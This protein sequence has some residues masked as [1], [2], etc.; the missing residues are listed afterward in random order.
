[1]APVS[2]ESPMSQRAFRLYD[3]MTRQVKELVPDTAGH[4]K[5]YSCGPTVYS[6]AHIC[7]FRSCLTADLVV[8]V[9]KALVWHVAWGSNMTCVCH[10]TEADVGDGAGRCAV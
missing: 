1:M 9:A 8:R 2:L 5:F 6:Y 4:L 3:T 7:N 10:R